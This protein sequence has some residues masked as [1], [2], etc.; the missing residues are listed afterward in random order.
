MS[1]TFI[2]LRGQRLGGLVPCLEALPQASTF[3]EQFLQAVILP[4]YLILKG[5]FSLTFIQLVF[6]SL[7]PQLDLTNSLREKDHESHTVMI[8]I[9]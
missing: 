1:Q 8:M 4:S 9:T 3:G 6:H 7:Q 2:S 5:R